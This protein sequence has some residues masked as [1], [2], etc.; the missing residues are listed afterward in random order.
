MIVRALG[1][2]ELFFRVLT[3]RWSH[4]PLSGAGAAMHGG[5]FNRPGLEALYLAREAVT[6]LAEFKQD[7]TFL[8]PGTICQYAA[9]ELRVVD[10]TAGYASGWDALWQDHDCDWRELLFNQRVQPPTW[11][12]GDEAILAGCA[13]ILFPSRSH[14]GGVNLVVFNSSILG[15]EFLRVLDPNHE[16]PRDQSSW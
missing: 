1:P 9:S 14:P 16:L 5:R 10:I 2:D 4:Q 6:A 12:M 11:D 3:P 15:P 13:G 7:N 8:S